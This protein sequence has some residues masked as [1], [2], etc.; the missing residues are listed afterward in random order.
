[1]KN[2]LSIIIPTYNRWGVL[3]KTLANTLANN[4][5]GVQIIVLDNDSNPDGLDD[6]LA[7]MASYESIPC[8]IIKNP[9]NI[10]GDGNIIRCIEV[11]ETPYVL[12]LGDDDFLSNDYLEKISHYLMQNENWGY[13]SFKDRPC[14]GGDRVYS[15]PVDMLEAC[16]DWS[17]LLFI[18]TTIFSKKMFCEGMLSAQR[19]QVTHSAHL[20]GMIKGWENSF[21]VGCNWKFLLSTKQLVVSGGHGRDHR[22]FDL[23]N[24]Y[25]GFPVL[26]FVFQDKRTHYAVRAAVR[27]GTKRIF[28]PRVL[29]KEFFYYTLQFGFESSWRRMLA[30]R[31][32]LSYSVGWRALFY[33]TY[34]PFVVLFAAGIG[35]FEKIK[36]D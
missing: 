27:G 17:E 11:C 9:I 19:A 20:V 5:A 16:R 13:I 31:R 12:V 1:L 35:L 8:R 15:S 22:S 29:A 34:L 18:S 28:K 3:V 26:E 33:R 32:G 30:M 25:A 36:Y 14:E 2:K 21:K 6:V 7:L 4:W 24:I 10:G 23:M